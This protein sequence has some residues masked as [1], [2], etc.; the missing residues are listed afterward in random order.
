MKWNQ[1]KAIK[2]TF[3]ETTT[4]EENNKTV[5]RTARVKRIVRHNPAYFPR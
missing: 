3:K 2:M 1:M 4:V 5:T